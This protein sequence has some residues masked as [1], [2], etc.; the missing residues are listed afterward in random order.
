MD[1]YYGHGTTNGK[2]TNLYLFAHR[3]HASTGGGGR[4][5]GVGQRWR[6]KPPEPVTSNIS[7]SPCGSYVVLGA[8]SGRCYLWST[9]GAGDG[10]GGDGPGGGGQSSGGAGG[11]LL[12][13][14]SAHNRP[15]TCVSF[16]SDGAILVTAGQDGIVNAWVLLDVVSTPEED[17]GGGSLRSVRTFSEHHLPVSALHSLPYANRLVSASSDRQL[18]LM[19]LGCGRTLARILLPA[20]IRSVTS[21]ATGRRIYAG[22]DDGVVY[23]V[24]LDVHALRE[25]AESATLV[26]V[27]PGTGS[28]HRNLLD[29]P[30]PSLSGS[31]LGQ[32]I[33]GISGAGAT[34]SASSAVAELKGHSRPVTALAV[35]DGEADKGGR[36]LLVSGSEDGTVRIWDLRTRA[37]SK[38][39]RPWGGSGGTTAGG[40]VGPSPSSATSCPVSSLVVVPRDGFSS[41]ASSIN[42]PFDVAAPTDGR[43]GRGGGSYADGAFVDLFHPLQRFPAHSLSGDSVPIMT[44]SRTLPVALRWDGEHYR[45]RGGRNVAAL[46]S[47][48]K[49]QRISVAGPRESAAIMMPEEAAEGDGDNGGGFLSF[50]TDPKKE[51]AEGVHAEDAE[52]AGL[53]SQLAD[54]K[55]TIRRWEK[56]NNK[57]ATKLKEA[58]GK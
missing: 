34:A 10:G 23:C 17:H 19:E 9:L 33:L 18:V 42:G 30:P 39:I 57:L 56:V 46:S 37:C 54:A 24:D 15:V 49:R 55:D 41:A 27:G 38:V 51:E 26:S 52:V 12:R 47:G 22:G 44:S 29:A 11:R 48:V 5:S 35:V 28:K 43:R 4:D 7:I 16:S 36:G 58:T 14:W 40:A 21:D 20:S 13:I 8:K 32:T 25:T 6:A 3:H 2:D 31:R 53:R 50:Y 45:D 1:V